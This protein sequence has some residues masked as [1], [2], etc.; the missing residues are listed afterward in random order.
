MKILIVK[1]SAIGDVIHTLPSL[2]ALR[3]R[4][5]TAHI[6]WVVEKAAAELIEDH[7]ALN[8]VIVSN[9]K[10]WIKGLWGSDRLNNL[11]NIYNFIKELRDTHYDFIIDFQGLLKSGVLVGLARGSRKAGYGRGMERDEGA[12]LFLNEHIPAV[13]M[14]QHAL[15][16]SLILLR[17]I[18]VPADEIEYRIPV[19]QNERTSAA[20]LLKECGVDGNRP[21]VAVNPITRWE[22]KRWSYRKFAELADRIIDEFSACV[23]FTGSKSDQDAIASIAAEMKHRA[24]NMAGRT[25]LKELAALYEKSA[26]A[27]TTDTGPMHLAAA[28]GTPVV[29]LFGPTAPWRTGPY[30]PGN[31][32][33]RAKL[34]CSPCFKR[35]CPTTK[36]MEQIGVEQVMEAVQ[37]LGLK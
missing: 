18:G 11:K 15:D 17:S 5:P 32:V 37:K 30:G 25:S 26:L 28:V 16:R 36:C 24:R 1:L 8:R 12:Y 33:I 23:V 35:K 31:Q 19:G 21:L 13:D 34:E 27:V 14:N 3:K 7:P 4:F 10:R 22:T 9:R 2:N 6:A 20:R 29:A